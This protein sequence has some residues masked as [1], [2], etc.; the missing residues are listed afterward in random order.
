MLFPESCES[1]PENLVILPL[2]L[3]AKWLK[4]ILYPPVF[5]SGITNINRRILF[6][7]Y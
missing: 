3:L 5:V 6:W 7:Y 4:F 1:I 2:S